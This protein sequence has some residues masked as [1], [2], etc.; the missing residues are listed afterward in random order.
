MEELEL[1]PTKRGDSL[2]PVEERHIDYI[3]EEEFSV[4]PEFLEFFLNEARR[5]AQDKKRILDR[6][7]KS[8]CHAVRSATT[9][10]GESDLLVKYDIQG[11]PLPVA[12][13]IEDK[14]RAGFQDDQPQRY[15][16]RG[17]EGTGKEW[18]AYWTCLVADAKYPVHQNDFDLS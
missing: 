4:N 9:A 1:S 11:S 5:T 17:K 3:L 16:E 7:E 12:I 13:L 2:S 18:S 8:Q 6:V 10:R 14:I 15:H